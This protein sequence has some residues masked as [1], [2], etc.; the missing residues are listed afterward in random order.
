MKKFHL[1][2]IKKVSYKVQSELLKEH[3]H[4]DPAITEL[5]KF[6]REWLKDFLESGF[7][8]VSCA[9][10]AF[11]KEEHLNEFPDEEITAEI[12]RRYGELIKSFQIEMY[13]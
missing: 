1:I 8:D 6:S 10:Y 3:T 11:D 5:M 9:I 7:A 4:L 12:I 2:T 13:R